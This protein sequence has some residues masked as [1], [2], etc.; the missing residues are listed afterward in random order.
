MAGEAWGRT[1]SAKVDGTLDS[2]GSSLTLEGE[3]SLGETLT[4][5]LSLEGD[6]VQ[7]DLTAQGLT[8]PVLSE[9]FTLR[10]LA[11]GSLEALPLALELGAAEPLE[12]A[13]GEN[14][15]AT[16]LRGRAEGTLRGSNLALQGNFGGL[17]LD[18]TLDVSSGSGS[19]TYSLADTT[20]RGPATGT[21]SIEEGTLTLDDGTVRTQARLLS[22]PLDAG[23]LGLPA[24]DAG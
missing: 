8:A 5:T 3:S 19:L 12:L 6:T 16:D 14:G 2:A 17:G 4:G 13:A 23:A 9:P 7:G 22:S 15:L 11:D 24:L 21:V 10:L 20:L 1:L 18:G